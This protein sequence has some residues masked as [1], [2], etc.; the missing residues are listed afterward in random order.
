MIKA[1]LLVVVLA[2]LAQFLPACG[3]SEQQTVIGWV[4]AKHSQPSGEGYTIVIN[5][6]DYQVPGWFWIEVKIGDLVKWDGKVWT[7]VK[8]A[9]APLGPAVD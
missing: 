6:V 9:F 7:I 3:D 2:S 5:H 4:E 1:I 8:K